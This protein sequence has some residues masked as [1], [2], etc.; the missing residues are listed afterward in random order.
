MTRA[1]AVALAGELSN[2]VVK[3]TVEPSC[4]CGRGRIVFRGARGE[5]SICV[6]VSD[7]ERVRAHFAGFQPAQVA[8]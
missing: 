4:G 8:A 7:E 6:L 2:E 3:V 5:H 1:E